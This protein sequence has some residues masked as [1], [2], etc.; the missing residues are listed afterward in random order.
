[1]HYITD[2][3]GLD[4]DWEYPSRRNGDKQDKE[5]F[6]T[7]LSEIKNALSIFDMLL[8]VSV[9]GKVQ[10]IDVSYDVL[11]ISKSVDFI[12]VM[13]YNYI[14]AD[15]PN[16][17]HH[18]NASGVIGSDVNTVENTID[19]WISRGAD[20]RKLVM[21]LSGFSRTMKLEEKCK[22]SLGAPTEEE[23][24]VAGTFTKSSGVLAYY[25]VC[26][27]KWNSRTCSGSSS[28]NAPYGSTD[29][30]FISYDDPESVAL[31]VKRIMIAKNLR[32]FLFWALDMD[33]FGNRCGTGTY[34]LIKTAKNMA[35][36]IEQIAGVCNDI[37]SSCPAPKPP[38]V[39]TTATIT[40]REKITTTEQTTTTKTP[41]TTTTT[42]ST[43][44]TVTKTTTKTTTTASTISTTISTTPKTTT[45]TTTT[46]TTTTT[47]TP[48]TTTTTTTEPIITFPPPVEFDNTI[49]RVCFFTDTARERKGEGKF[50]ILARFE[51]DLCSHLVYTDGEI[52]QLGFGNIFEFKVPA[53]RN[54][55]SISAIL[56]VLKTFIQNLNLNKL[57]RY[58]ISYLYYFYCFSCTN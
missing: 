21:G 18:T 54:V 37:E 26:K 16:T 10:N 33:D 7:F 45:T 14:A 15:A 40:G 28:V 53:F 34:P 5:N 9:D 12:N 51:D 49:A 20:P 48:T 2:F 44:P 31:K 42:T 56:L 4:I 24:G 50:D 23:G 11:S 13:S 1:L 43:T 17:G 47:T 8:T 41:T 36:G 29:T 22:H 32:G 38:V 39:T 6:A 46:P 27:T 25:E 57:S 52:V 58:L 35:L 30:D 19:A 3:D 55:V